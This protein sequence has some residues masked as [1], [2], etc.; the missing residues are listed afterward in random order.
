PGGNTEKLRPDRVEI[1]LA[2]DVEVR[3]YQRRDPD[4]RIGRER[5]SQIRPPTEARTPRITVPPI[6]VGWISRREVARVTNPPHA[7]HAL[8]RGA[9]RR[10]PVPSPCTGVVDVDPYG[11]G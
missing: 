10:P 4:Q 2:D 8:H 11:V 3:G 7:C 5:A 9:G 6:R 1:I